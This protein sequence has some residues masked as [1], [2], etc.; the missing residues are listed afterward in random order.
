MW[1]EFVAKVTGKLRIITDIMSTRKMNKR[2]KG[3]LT[4]KIDVQPRII[5]SDFYGII[6]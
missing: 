6:L 5:I 3:D 2:F 1:Y 4:T